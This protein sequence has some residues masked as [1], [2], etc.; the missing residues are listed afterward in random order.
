MGGV[1]PEENFRPLNEQ[2][3][4][5]IPEKIQEIWSPKLI[6]FVWREPDAT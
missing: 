2:R 3:Y 1:M 4:F 5:Q 6:Q